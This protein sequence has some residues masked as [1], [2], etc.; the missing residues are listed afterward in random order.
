MKK[1]GE[2]GVKNARE[3]LSFSS[4][5]VA[6]KFLKK[7]P[8]KKTHKSPYAYTRHSRGGG[9]NQVYLLDQQVDED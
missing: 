1:I 2:N 7:I 3:R 8:G 4:L 6:S 9:K 5:T